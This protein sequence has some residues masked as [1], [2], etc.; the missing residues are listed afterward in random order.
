MSEEGSCCPICKPKNSIIQQTTTPHHSS[1]EASP[2]SIYTHK[3]THPKPRSQIERPSRPYTQG[4]MLPYSAVQSTTA[5]SL[6]WDDDLQEVAQEFLHTDEG[7]DQSSVSV[8]H[9]DDSELSHDSMVLSV[10]AEG[11]QEEKHVIPENTITAS[12]TTES[13]YSEILQSNITFADSE[14]EI[15]EN[16]QISEKSNIAEF[17][18]E[19]P[20]IVF[21]NETL[22]GPL[23]V[24]PMNEM[25]LE[26]ATEINETIFKTSTEI[27]E[28]LPQFVNPHLSTSSSVTSDSD[29]PDA[30]VIPS[31]SA[32]EKLDNPKSYDLQGISKNN[33]F[34]NEIKKL[35]LSESKSKFNVKVNVSMQSISSASRESQNDGKTENANDGRRLGSAQPSFHSSTSSPQI[36]YNDVPQDRNARPFQVHKYLG[37]HD[38]DKRILSTSESAMV[39]EHITEIL[40]ETESLT[41]GPS[42]LARD[43]PTSTISSSLYGDDLYLDASS[44]PSFISVE[45]PPSMMV[46]QKSSKSKEVVVKDTE[47]PALQK[48][49]GPTIPSRNSDVTPSYMSD[50]YRYFKTAG[51]TTTVPG[52]TYHFA[53]NPN[54]SQPSSSGDLAEMGHSAIEASSSASFRNPDIAT[55]HVS[56]LD[57]PVSS[58]NIRPTPETTRDTKTTFSSGPELITVLDTNITTELASPDAMIVLKKDDISESSGLEVKMAVNENDTTESSSSEVKMI[59]NEG[60][61]NAGSSGPEVKMILNKDDTINS[62]NSE[63]RKVLNM[64][65]TMESYD[66]EV[67]SETNIEN[68]TESSGPEVVKISNVDDITESTGSKV[69]SVLNVDDT[70]ESSGPEMITVLNMDDTTDS[71]GSEVITILNMNISTESSSPEVITVLNTDDTTESFDP[72]KIALLDEGNTTEVYGLEVN[73]VLNKGDTTHSSS[74]EARTLL[75]KENDATES[76]GNSFEAKSPLPVQFSTILLKTTYSPFLAEESDS[77]LWT[78]D[79][80]Y[81]TEENGISDFATTDEATTT[82]P[83]SEFIHELH[84]VPAEGDIKDLPISNLLEPPRSSHTFSKTKSKS[85]ETVNEHTT[86]APIMLTPSTSTV[87]PVTVHHDVTTVPEPHTSMVSLTTTAH[88]SVVPNTTGVHPTMAV[89]HVLSTPSTMTKLVPQASFPTGTTPLTSL[90]TQS[91]STTPTVIPG[92]LHGSCELEEVGKT[93][94]QPGNP[95]VTC[96]C[97]SDLD[98]ECGQVQCPPLDCP[99]EELQLPEGECCPRCKACEVQVGWELRQ[100]GEGESWTDP[101]HACSVCVC[102]SGVASCSATFCPERLPL[103]VLENCENVVCPELKCTLGQEVR[104][105]PGRCCPMCAPVSRR[106]VWWGQHLR[107]FDGVLLQH[108]AFCAYTMA[109]HCSQGLFTIYT[110]FGDSTTRLAVVVIVTVLV[111]DIHLELRRSGTVVVDGEDVMLPYLTSTIAIF[112]HGHSIVVNTDVGLQV[113]WSIGG[114]VEVVIGEEHGGST[115]GLCGNLNNMPQDDLTLPCGHVSQSVEDFLEGWSM[116]KDCIAPPSVHQCSASTLKLSGSIYELAYNSCSAIKGLS[117]QECHHLVPPD[118]YVT[119]CRREVCECQGNVATCLCAT[120]SLYSTLCTRA[121]LVLSWRT[122]HLCEVTCPPG[123]MWSEC[124]PPCGPLDCNYTTSHTL[125]QDSQDVSITSAFTPSLIS[126]SSSF[127]R[128]QG[129]CVP[130]CTC[131]HGYALKDGTCVMQEDC[132]K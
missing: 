13:S 43:H 59:L 30:R 122:P 48:I 4:N 124:V 38:K 103:H 55:V 23:T 89:P 72:E 113:V 2:S 93:F 19:Q 49:T 12:L 7:R 9:V 99:R 45:K 52:P 75:N 54:F 76:Y 125:Y 82:I 64:N 37:D 65:D 35:G 111:G 31:I 22:R 66:S 88:S 36:S 40:R 5:G 95:C 11:K 33:S 94:N 28:S 131:P 115:C 81:V 10:E 123:M 126:S 58:V 56:V 60:D 107:T 18:A 87:S 27:S 132:Y 41:E 16:L 50:L 78:S 69:T 120:F 15:E 14:P 86:T 101:A 105:P 118:P 119:A 70:T 129:P 44:L 62:S 117:F 61:D 90:S 57:S 102:H 112:A 8:R 34:H 104:H 71:S 98:W 68:N 121:G 53:S 32:D 77:Q 47:N 97:T 39:S 20:L 128:C 51:K 85:K 96:I 127:S 73:T 42:S 3:D 79:I 106:C 25:S 84:K 116:G 80:K 100:Y 46:M 108:H 1:Q 109:A 92:S 114:Q 24:H 26:T 91:P 21:R 83:I 74:Q 67:V 6:I 17:T 63:M 29:R 110:K 130:G